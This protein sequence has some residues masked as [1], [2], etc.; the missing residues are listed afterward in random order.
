MPV[1]DIYIESETVAPRPFA[2]S[3]EMAV[4]DFVRLVGPDL[5]LPGDRAWALEDTKTGQVIDAGRSLAESGVK[6]GALLRVIKSGQ[7]ALTCAHCGLVDRTYVGRPEFCRECGTPFTAAPRALEVTVKRPEAQVL[8]LACPLNMLAADLLR[9]A[10]AGYSG[11]HSSWELRNQDGGR[12]LDLALSLEANGLRGRCD[13]YL[14]KKAVKPVPW[15]LLS[16]IAG[17]VLAITGISFIW[18]HRPLPSGVVLLPPS[19]AE[20]HSS[21]THQFSVR[22][23]EKNLRARW[24]LSPEV[25]TIDASGLYRA[26]DKV[27]TE[28]HVTVRAT[29]AN[30]KSSMFAGIELLPDSVTPL[31]IVLT[32]LSA[33]LEAGGTSK[34]EAHIEGT[35]NTQLHWSPPKLGT[36]AED[37][38][39]TAPAIIPAASTDTVTVA[40]ADGKSTASATVNLAPVSVQLHTKIASIRAAETLQLNGVVRGSSNHRLNW[41]LNGPGSIS[42]RGLYYAPPLLTTPQDVKIT[43]SSLADPGK[44]ATISLQLLPAVVVTIEPTSATAF[45]QQRVPFTLHV[46]GTSDSRV[47]LTLNGPGLLLPNGIYEAPATIPTT[48]VVTITASSMADPNKTAKAQVTLNPL[49]VWINPTLMRMRASQRIQ[50]VAVV[51]GSTN[52]ALRWSLAGPGTLSPSGIYSAPAMI[53]S[54]QSARV[55]ATSAA[56]PTQSASVIIGLERSTSMKSGSLVWTGSLMKNESVTLDGASA[57][58][59]TLQGGLPGIPVRISI[60]NE[61]EFM[62][63]EPPG[64]RNNWIKLTVRS[65]R[66]RGNTF[67][68]TWVV[69]P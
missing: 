25:G 10:L 58:V 68:V 44:S 22:V 31:K 39:Y 3:S 18:K 24:S 42:N 37:G 54:E 6:P 9:Q 29:T 14:Q 62:I 32:P 50:I 43:A 17:V 13:L 51:T 65:K 26:P 64:P 1:L 30:P 5:N 59:G 67:R 27:F 38:V 36:I 11:S 49:S 4:E 45:I 20:L 21:Q 23:G 40:T 8:Q 35:S 52:T 55:T 41:S 57:S 60:D 15:A 28:Q 66:G 19:T 33:T 12:I 46:T 48:K 53:P 47:T 61:R 2:A 56:D 7:P 16:A 34:F 69:L 63:L